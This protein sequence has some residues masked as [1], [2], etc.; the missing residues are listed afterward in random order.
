MNY[1][2]SI[3]SATSRLHTIIRRHAI[4]ELKGRLLSYSKASGGTSFYVPVTFEFDNRGRCD[5]RF[6]CEVYLLSNG[7]A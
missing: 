7:N 2:H 4:G 5:S 6:V 1:L 3:Q